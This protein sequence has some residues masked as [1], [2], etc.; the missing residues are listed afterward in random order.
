M[1]MQCDCKPLAQRF[2]TFELSVSRKSRQAPAQQLEVSGAQGVIG[3]GGNLLRRCRPLLGIQ[4]VI[5]RLLP[6]TRRLVGAGGACMQC[7]HIVCCAC[8][9]QSGE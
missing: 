6:V 9:T 7:A 4:I 5:E 1:R 8:R 2:E 3:M